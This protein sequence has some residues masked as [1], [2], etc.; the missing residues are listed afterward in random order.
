MRLLLHKGIHNDL[1]RDHPRVTAFAGRMRT[2]N[3]TFDAEDLEFARCVDIDALYQR[4]DRRTYAFLASLGVRGADADDIQQKV[5]MR[6]L[7]ALRKKP[8]EGHFRGW[9]FQI[10][11]N[12]A[13]DSMRKKRPEP[14]DAE[15]AEATISDSSAPDQG[16]IDAEYKAAVAKC[17]ERLDDVQ[18]QIVRGR[19]AGE[20][21]DVICERLQIT[22]SRAHRQFFDAKQALTVCLGQAGLGGPS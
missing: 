20:S 5:W 4:Y 22:A 11:R 17:V 9:L 6:V 12:T 16:L 1:L 19:L 10:V 18:Q 13:I 15:I 8:F 2:T 7:E 14:L 21:Y 3:D